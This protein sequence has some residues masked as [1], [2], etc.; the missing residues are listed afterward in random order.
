[1]VS[2]PVIPVLYRKLLVRKIRVHINILN[3]VIL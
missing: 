2:D 3:V 1:M